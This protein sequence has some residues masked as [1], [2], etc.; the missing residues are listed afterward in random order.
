M[1]KVISINRTPGD[2]VR[3]T[4]H[5]SVEDRGAYQDILD[6]IVILGQDAD[7]PSLPDDDRAI[8][9]ILGWSVGKWRRTKARLCEG[10]L[11][12]LMVADGRI[13]QV[14]IAIEIEEARARI[15]GAYVAGKA[16][17]ESRRKKAEMR[18]RML[19]GRSTDVATD[20]ERKAQRI[21]NGTRT[22]REPV[23]SHEPLVTN[24][25]S[26]SVGSLKGEIPSLARSS[27]GG[28]TAAGDR[29][30]WE[31]VWSQRAF[32]M[33]VDKIRDF[34]KAVKQRRKPIGPGD[35]DFDA[36]FQTEFGMTWGYWTA[37]SERHQEYFEMVAKASA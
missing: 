34:V 19:N 14:R 30:H 28:G 10:P 5:L 31:P 17:G 6:H 8:A 1:T 16:S 13:C 12:V 25:D 2:F 23:T 35:E 36:E 4:R 21:A 18:E 11:A 24:H 32:Q 37:Q 3:D 27:G 33:R 26:S 15:A 29:R 9:N 20:V 7:P 22:E